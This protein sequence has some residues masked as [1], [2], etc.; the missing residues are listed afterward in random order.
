MD[1]ADN[2]A[3]SRINPNWLVNDHGLVL[4]GD[5]GLQVSLVLVQ[6][7]QG[8]LDAVP[9]IAEDGVLC[10]NYLPSCSH[11]RGHGVGHVLRAVDCAEDLDLAVDVNLVSVVDFLAPDGQSAALD[12]HADVHLLGM[13]EAV[14]DN[15]GLPH[16]VPGIPKDAVRSGDGELVLDHLGFHDAGHVLRSVIRAQDFQ[17]LAVLRNITKAR[18]YVVVVVVMVAKESPKYEPP[19][20]GLGLGLL[21]GL[22][23]PGASQD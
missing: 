11:E 12:G 10:G 1:T 19:V 6:H 20:L 8:L 2:A 5:L 3:S 16:S 17:L 15:Q 18:L 4:Y 9:R 13:A 7:N 14:E 23:S 22:R 21:I